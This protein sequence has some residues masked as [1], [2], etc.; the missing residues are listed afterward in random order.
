MIILKK[1]MLA[2]GLFVVSGDL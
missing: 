2:T 1:T